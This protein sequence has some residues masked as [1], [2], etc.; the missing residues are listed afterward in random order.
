VQYKNIF[1]F[2]TDKELSLRV[3]FVK[4]FV[5]LVVNFFYHK[6]HNGNPLLGTHYPE[7]T[8]TR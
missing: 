2:L 3:P 5:F 6:V 8:A 7:K 4:I 1:K